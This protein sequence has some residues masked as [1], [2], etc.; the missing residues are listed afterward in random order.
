[1]LETPGTWFRGDKKGRNCGKLQ[2]TICQTQGQHD[3]NNWYFLIENH[4]TTIKANEPRIISKDD[5]T[6]GGSLSGPR[7]GHGGQNYKY[8]QVSKQVNPVFGRIPVL[9]LKKP[10]YPTAWISGASLEIIVK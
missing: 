7:R 4:P 2:K 8:Y 5:D 9:D 10:D 3:L 1:M 6:H